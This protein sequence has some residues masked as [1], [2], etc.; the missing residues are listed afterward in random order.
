ML[1]PPPTFIKAP[2]ATTCWQQA[3]VS[4]TTGILPELLRGPPI[5]WRANLDDYCYI[6]D[7]G[8]FNE[9]YPVPA[10]TDLSDPGKVG[11]YYH[12]GTATTTPGGMSVS[13]GGYTYIRRIR[14]DFLHGPTVAAATGILC[15]WCFTLSITSRDGRWLTY[16]I[17][18]LLP[19]LVSIRQLAVKIQSCRLHSPRQGY[20]QDLGH[21]LRKMLPRPWL[22]ATDLE[23]HGHGQPSYLSSPLGVDHGNEMRKLVDDNIESFIRGSD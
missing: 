20:H 23:S 8:I 5:P 2:G 21:V 16:R 4:F 11:A 18:T 12:D 15:L 14:L 3:R 10:F 13:V 7:V 19:L 9:P 17:P 1:P 22:E 6:D